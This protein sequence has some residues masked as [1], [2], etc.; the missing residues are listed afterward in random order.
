[1][2]IIANSN[3]SNP[4]MGQIVSNLA[5]AIYG[6]PEARQRAGYYSAEGANAQASAAKSGEE[7][8]GLKLKNDATANLPAT[9]ANLYAPV[10]GETPQ[11]RQ[12]RI[13]QGLGAF[14]QAGGGNSAEMGTGIKS[15]L[16][17]LYALGND[18][19]M[20]RSEVLDGKTPDQNFSP[21]TARADKVAGRNAAADKSKADSV[22]NIEQAGALGRVYAAPVVSRPGDTTYLAPN[23]PRRAVMGNNGVVQGAPTVDTVRANAGNQILALPG[24]Q[25]PTPNLANVFSGGAGYKGAVAKPKAVTGKNINDA[26]MAAAG[27]VPGATSIDASHKTV[28]DPN[29]EAAFPADKVALARNAA[30]AILSKTGDAQ[31][32]GQAYLDALGVKPGDKFG[33]HTNGGLLTDLFG[34]GGNPGMVPAT[35]AAAPGAAPA[36][37]N[38]APVVTSPQQLPPPAQRQK[39]MTITTPKGD[40]SWNGMGWVPAG[41]VN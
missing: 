35:P 32:A 31:A 8:R 16:S 13:A 27:M 34:I 18:D 33:Q 1:M 41:K 3:Y 30:G 15:T 11:A 23:D 39:G 6:D 7:T 2:P 5:A 20:T 29:F 10:L 14:V 12:A 40:M 24:G 4:E 21:S 38:A 17:S 9:L 28:L 26:V 19:D 25:D 37:P 36:A 22:A